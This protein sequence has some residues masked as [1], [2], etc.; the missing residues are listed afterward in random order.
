MIILKSFLV[1]LGILV[2]AIA[3]GFL[4]EAVLIPRLGH[5]TGLVASGLLLSL[6]V[7][8]ASLASIRWTRSSISLGTPLVSD[9]MV[10]GFSR[11][12]ATNRSPSPSPLNG[13]WPVHSSNRMQPRE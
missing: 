9:A 13:G 4:R 10:G 11:M 2:L 5:V 12:C 8:G 6:L 1:W 3:N 7:F